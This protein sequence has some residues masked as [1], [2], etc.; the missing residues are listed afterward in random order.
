MYARG[1]IF[2]DL[3]TVVKVCDAPRPLMHEDINFGIPSAND[4]GDILRI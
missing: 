3:M 1:T 4:I 2:P